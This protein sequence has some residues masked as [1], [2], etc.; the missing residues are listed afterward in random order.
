LD[1]LG[2]L[3][4]KGPLTAAE[5]KEVQ[6]HPALGARKLGTHPHLQDVCKMVAEHHEKWDGSGYPKRLKEH[7]ISVPG[8]ILGVVEVFDSLSTKR[9]YKEPWELQKM[10]DFFEAQR[11]RAFDPETLDHFLALLEIHG[12]EWLAQPQKDLQL[13]KEKRER[14]NA[15]R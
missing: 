12:D 7:E 10:L 1:D 4:K 11:G 9:S 6:K 2:F 15:A 8:R 5:Y 3:T 13:A 14:E